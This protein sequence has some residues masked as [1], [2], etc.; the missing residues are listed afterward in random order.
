MVFIL[1]TLLREIRAMSQ[2]D[3]FDSK[4]SEKAFFP[5]IEIDIVFISYILL[6]FPSPYFP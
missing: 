1:E 5:F 6:S 3:H 4:Q 2:L